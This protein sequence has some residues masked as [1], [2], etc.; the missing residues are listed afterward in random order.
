MTSSSSQSLESFT[1]IYEVEF[2]SV[3]RG[4]H[5]YKA[6]WSPTL[7]ESLTCRKDERNEANEHDEYAIGTYLDDDVPMELSCLHF[8]ESPPRQQRTSQSNRNKDAGKWTCC[9]CIFPS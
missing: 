6:K 8:F 5:V 7:G 9:A 2:S 4:H 3:I 1:F